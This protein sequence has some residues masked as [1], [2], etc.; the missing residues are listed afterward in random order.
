MLLRR[1]SCSILLLYA[2]ILSGCMNKHFYTNPIGKDIQMGDPFVFLDNG[3]YY[4][5]G[6]TGGKAFKVW[7]SSDFREWEYAGAAYDQTKS[8]WGKS[9]FWAPEIFRYMGKY[10]MVYSCNGPSGTEGFRLCIAVADKPEGP[11][12]DIHAPWLDNNWSC[13]DADVFI[14]TDSVPYLFFDKV[15][16]IQNPFH[17]YGMIYMVK[18]SKDLSKA[19]TKPKLVVQAEQ[20]WEEID[21]QHPS[22]CNEGAFVFK[23]DSTYYITFSAGHYLSPNYAIGYATAKS[24]Y[25]PWIKGDDNPIVSKNLSIGI[26][27]PG[28][29]SITWTNDKKNL[30]MVYHVHGNPLKLGAGRK[31]FIDKLLIDQYGKLKLLGPT[32]KKQPCPRN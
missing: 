1:I 14:D 27:G 24:P 20:P 29:N 9:N 3:C 30:F 4:L 17:L 13:I 21:P 26:S 28:H 2:I 19:E 31:V 15:G 22:S 7:K 6:T 23:H 12:K 8:E 11:F 25:G 32:L 18:L 16:V 10:Y 5:Y